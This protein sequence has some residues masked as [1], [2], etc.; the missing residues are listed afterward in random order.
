MKCGTQVLW[1]SARKKGSGTP[2][3]KAIRWYH[4]DFN[5]MENPIELEYIKKSSGTL[6]ICDGTI[7]V[8]ISADDEPDWGG[9]YAALN[10]S[11]KCDKCGGTI[12]PH[13]P[14]NAKQLTAFVQDA[15][16]RK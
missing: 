6:D 7:T 8:S 2:Y 10:I 9:H 12:F 1:V 14:Q 4:S 5:S 3:R 16:A 11:Y 15:I 13:L